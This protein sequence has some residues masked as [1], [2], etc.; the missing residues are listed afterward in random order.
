MTLS[1]PNIFNYA[2]YRVF[3]NDYYHF[4][5]QQDNKFSHRLIAYKTGSSSAGWFSDVVGGRI[6][7][8]GTYLLKLS[9]LFKLTAREKSYF[10]VLVGYDQAGSLDEKNA[11]ME[12]MMSFKEL[13]ASIVNKNQFAFY[14]TWYIPAIRELL[15]CHDFKDDYKALAKELSPPISPQRA[16]KAIEILK[17]LG[18]VK[19]N[20]S[21]HLKPCD[22]IIKKDPHFK[23]L[24]WA[25]FMRANMELG[26]EAL[27][28]FK[29]ENR[30]I[31][32]VTICLSEEGK[33]RASEEIAELRKKLLAISEQDQ[34]RNNVFQ[35]N[36]QLFPLTD[37]D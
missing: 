1:K 24:H 23:S 36:I 20:R 19:A 8:T 33:N 10:E 7:L 28:R 34:K 21:G 31:S 17:S 18:F 11:F 14:S 3:L 35:C 9:R 26:I 25:N 30:D 16:K 37:L 32:A 22:P 4:L 6:N 5:K 27:D 13:N 15:F 29:K 2:S 12:K